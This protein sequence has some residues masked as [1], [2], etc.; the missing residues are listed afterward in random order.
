MKNVLLAISNNSAFFLF[1]QHAPEKKLHLHLKMTYNI[2][3]IVRKLLNHWHI[4]IYRSYTALSS[5]WMKLKD[6][7]D[8]LLCQVCATMD[9]LRWAKSLV[10]Q[11]VENYDFLV[12]RCLKCQVALPLIWICSVGSGTSIVSVIT[13]LKLSFWHYSYF[14]EVDVLPTS[15]NLD[16]RS[17]GGGGGWGGGGGGG[18]SGRQNFLSY[19][20]IVSSY[21][22]TYIRNEKWKQGFAYNIFH[23]FPG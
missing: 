14:R 21:R 13:V 15:S 2:Y 9:M 4:W 18:G 22:N 5:Y 17:V 12:R 3:K 8:G 1:I 11:E 7:K 20:Q 23:K 19:G 6:K 10:I 16:H